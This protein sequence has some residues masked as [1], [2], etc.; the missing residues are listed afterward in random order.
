[1]S[2]ETELLLSHWKLH[3]GEID[4]LD[5]NVIKNIGEED[6]DIEDIL[7]QHFDDADLW[8]ARDIIEEVRKVFKL[9]F[10]KDLEKD[11]PLDYLISAAVY[12]GEE[13]ILR[14][15]FCATGTN[16][17]EQNNIRMNL[18]YWFERRKGYPKKILT[19]NQLKK[20]EY[21]PEQLYDG[22]AP[23]NKMLKRK[24]KK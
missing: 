23:T 8:Y 17:K 4:D 11:S 1:M 2:K 15:L 19:F 20:M 9:M 12:A 16:K 5:E 13:G 22:Y 21:T 3:S 18:S 14:A 24:D 6:Y 7:N 10:Q